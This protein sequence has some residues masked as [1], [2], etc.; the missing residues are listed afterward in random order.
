MVSRFK[1]LGELSSEETEETLTNKE[2]RIIKQITINDIKAAD[3]L[4][5]DLMGGGVTARK[6]FVKEHSKDAGKYNAE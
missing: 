5:E 2:T 6:E 4:F 1:G 3:K